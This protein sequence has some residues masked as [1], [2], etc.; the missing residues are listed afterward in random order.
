M[1][2]HTWLPAAKRSHEYTLYYFV[3]LCFPV[4]ARNEQD[5]PWPITG[6]R[7]GSHT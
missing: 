3:F 2:M 6:P 5:W 4:L 1:S 7:S